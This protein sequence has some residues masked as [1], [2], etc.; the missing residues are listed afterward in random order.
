M[1]E[2]DDDGAVHDI[3]YHAGVVGGAGGQHIV[4]FCDIG[5]PPFAV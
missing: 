5:A 2:R 4:K 3:A 1:G